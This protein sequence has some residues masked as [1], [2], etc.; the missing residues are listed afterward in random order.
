[1]KY[2]S[3]LLFFFISL[4]AFSQNYVSRKSHIT[5]VNGDYV[6]G[7]AT[8][9]IT[10]DGEDILFTNKKGN[11]VASRYKMGETTKGDN[12][13]R[14][15]FT[16]ASEGTTGKDELTQRGKDTFTNKTYKIVYEI[17]LRD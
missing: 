8:S 6:E 15:S 9:Y 10:I 14:W 16:P 7:K 17:Q 5:T 13:T 11:K 3:L 2:I 1:M 12:V 4:S